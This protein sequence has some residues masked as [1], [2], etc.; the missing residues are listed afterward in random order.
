VK[1]PRVSREPSF[2]SFGDRNR[3]ARVVW[4]Y[5]LDTCRRHLLAG[6]AH[7]EALQV[8]S[9]GGPMEVETRSTV[10]LLPYYTHKAAAIPRKWYHDAL[11]AVLLP[12]QC[13]AGRFRCLSSTC[14]LLESAALPHASPFSSMQPCVTV[15]AP[16]L[17]NHRNSYLPFICS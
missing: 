3:H 6:S 13:F 5:L 4:A 8:A 11:I 2:L 17:Y 12:Y 1:A 14:L 10:L 7:K 15:P 9:P 16:F